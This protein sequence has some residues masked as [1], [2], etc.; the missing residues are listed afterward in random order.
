MEEFFKQVASNVA[1][2]MEAAGTLVIA[3]GAALALASAL[4]S[5]LPLPSNGSIRRNKD[6]WLRFGTW[7][8]LGLEFELAADVV[9]SAIAPTWS[10]IGQLGAIAVIRTFL[11]YFL[12]RDLDKYAEPATVGPVPE[13]PGSV[14]P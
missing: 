2:G 13:M 9:R 3:I 7:Q 8:L 1:L 6:V 14:A 5:A 4:R 11:N 12:E 10:D